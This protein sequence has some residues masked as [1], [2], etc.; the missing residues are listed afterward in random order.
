MHRERDASVAA[1]RSTGTALILVK[2][3]G[4]V[5]NQPHDL[6]DRLGEW[7]S[8]IRRGSLRERC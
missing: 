4:P 6:I 7:C 3:Q 2:H 5:R 8:S 1:Q